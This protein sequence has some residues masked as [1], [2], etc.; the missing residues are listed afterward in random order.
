ME[1]K[2]CLITG[3]T[4]GLGRAAARELGRLGATLILVGRNAGKG[5]AVATGIARSGN[6]KVEFIP[7]DL[8][9]LAQVRALARSVHERYDH[10]DVL[11]NNAGA[12]FDNFGVSQDGVEL[13]FATNHLGHFLLT[14]LVSDLL[15]KSEHARIINVASGTHTSVPRFYEAPPTAQNYDRKSAYAQSKL[16]NVVFTYELAKRL[17]GKPVTVNALDPGG[18]ATA[19][20]R[21]NG[22]LPWLKHIVYYLAK[23]KLL[24]PAK[25]A[26]TILYLA[27]SPAVNGT[28]G[29]Y[30]FEKREVK[31]SDASYDSESGRRLWEMS[32]KLAGLTEPMPL[33]GPPS[34]APVEH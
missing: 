20:G 16:A 21:N 2:V 23:R 17:R 13:T 4:S 8:G 22:L 30:F 26:E 33:T 9:S 28:S 10:L 32:I 3:A 5:R 19:L 29:K 15:L 6:P 25:G 18:V 14:C 12:K 7:A 1:G 24:T 11:I 34:Q 27:T 31:S